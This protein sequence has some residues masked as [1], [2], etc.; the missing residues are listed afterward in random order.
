MK[1][2]HFIIN[3]IAGK[4][5]IP[6]EL[7]NVANYFPK[8]KYQVD[9]KISRYPGHAILLTKQSEK[10]GA[11]IIVACGGDGTINEVASCLVNKEIAL[12]I[13]PI[14]SGNGLAAS[15]KIPRNVHKAISIIKNQPI[16][17]IDVATVNGKPFLSNMGIG[18]DAMVISNFNKSKKRKFMAYF[19]AVL[20]ALKHHKNTEPLRVEMNGVV[21]K[22]SPFMFFV[23]NS[24]VMGYDM[25]LTRMASMKDGLLDVVVIDAI[26]KGEMLFLGILLFLRA[27]TF[28]RKIKYFKVRELKIEF[29]AHKNKHFMQADGELQTVE[30]GQLEVNLQANGLKVIAP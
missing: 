12:A 27:T 9:V 8:N 4:G 26:T 30:N 5:R 11:D 29:E 28:F 20:K 3:P 14:G 7:E 18:F 23:S 17:T 13:V 16:Q 21:M 19:K 22:T 10:D 6:K 24:K 1:V 2:V 25:S 15:L